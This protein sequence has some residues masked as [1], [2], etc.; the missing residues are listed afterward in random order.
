[1]EYDYQ[2][3]LNHCHGNTQEAWDKIKLSIELYYP[4]RS[5]FIA[6]SRLKSALKVG[7]SLKARAKRKGLKLS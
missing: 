6:R 4:R 1:M 7:K 5:N 3:V 2:T